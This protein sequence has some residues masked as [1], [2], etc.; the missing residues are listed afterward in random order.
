MVFKEYRKCPNCKKKMEVK[1][2]YT[3]PIIICYNCNCRT[4]KIIEEV[5]NV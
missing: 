1:P 3:L 2:G 4:I 5:K